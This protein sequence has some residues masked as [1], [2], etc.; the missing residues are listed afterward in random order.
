VSNYLRLVVVFLA[1]INPAAV[2][3]AMA[4]TSSKGDA[5]ARWLM[6]AIGASLAAVLYAA[7]TFGA[8]PLLDW[9][10]IE[11]ESF[12]VAAGVVMATV[13]VYAVW[14]GRLGDYTPDAGAQAA[15]F[16]LGLPLLAGPAGLIAALSYSV[17]KGAGKTIGAICVGVIVAAVLVAAR[18][19]KAAPALDAVARVTGALLVAVAAGLIVSGV[20]AI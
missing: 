14:S 18:P 1:A 8:E 9:L 3:M 6:P 11:P 12:R 20:R 4:A 13:G 15:F 16:P 19:A 7:A 2:A 5:R 17:D 10:Q